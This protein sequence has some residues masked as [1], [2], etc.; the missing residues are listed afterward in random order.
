MKTIPTTASERSNTMNPKLVIVTDLGLLKAY[1]LDTTERGTPRLELIEQV[2]LDDAHRRVVEQVTDLAGR[3]A[4]PTAK[5]WGAPV[6]DDHNLRLAIKHRLIKQ[7]ARHISRLS[8]TERDGLWLVAHKEINK[9]IVD[10]LPAAVR[11]RL[12]RAI[13]RDL[14]KAPQRRLLAALKPKPAPAAGNL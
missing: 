6:A 14:V 13:P 8:R 3:R 5:N 9:A 2:R 1:R 12:E 4:G 7:I 11:P 10:A